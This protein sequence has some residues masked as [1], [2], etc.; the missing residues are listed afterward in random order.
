MKIKIDKVCKKYRLD[1]E[2]VRLVELKFDLDMYYKMM[3]NGILHG[4]DFHRD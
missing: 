2:L 3:V 1:C 4:Y